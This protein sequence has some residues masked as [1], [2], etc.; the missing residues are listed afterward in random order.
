MSAEVRQF[1]AAIALIRRDRPD[2]S[3]EWLA[4]WNAGRECYQFVEAHKIEDETFRQS[5]LREISWTTG[6]E[7]GRDF[8]VAGGA[9]ARVQFAEVTPCDPEPVWFVVEFYLVE[10]MGRRQGQL[11]SEHDQIAW[12]TADEVQAGRTRDGRPLCPR[13]CSLIKRADILQ[14]WQA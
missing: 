7:T 6:L 3:D 5:L 14:P 13:L 12:L 11:L 8:L 9:R 1:I 2:G 4:L 10:L